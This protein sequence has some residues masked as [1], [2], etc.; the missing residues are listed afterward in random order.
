MKKYHTISVVLPAY[1]GLPLIKQAVESVLNQ[2]FS[3]FEFIITDDKS[4]DGTYEYLESIRDHRIRL[5]QNEVNLGLFPN[6]NRGI[7]MANNELIH[8]W[9]QDDIMLPDCLL[10]TIKFHNRYPEMAFAFSKYLLI[11]SNGIVIGVNPIN[12]NDLINV[13]GHAISSLLYGS[14]SGNITNVSLKKSDVER[15]GYFN[16]SMKY[17]GDFDMWCKLSDT[18]PVGLIQQHLIK[19][20]RHKN[21]LSQKPYMWIHRLKENK[22]IFDAFLQRVPEKKRFYLIKAIKWR[23]Y[24]QYFSLF[25]RLILIKKFNLAK[26]YAI[27]LNKHHNL[28]LQFFRWLILKIL[29]IVDKDR[30]LLNVLFFNKLRS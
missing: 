21:Q 11:D 16:E 2:N 6:L 30:W 3:D 13:E 17:S 15:V 22:Q 27:E 23:I 10:Q 4:T 28:G 24:N 19:L 18:K 25:F 7:K 5:V 29:K 1:N 26:E 12:P 20:R 9:L 8:L 14:I